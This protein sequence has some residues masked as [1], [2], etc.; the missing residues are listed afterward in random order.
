MDKK[1]FQEYINQVADV[2]YLKPVKTPGIR[3]DNNAND[4]VRY[5]DEWV[6]L[7]AKENPTLGFKFKKLKN[8]IKPC[9]LGCGEMVENQIVEKRLATTP[10]THW[11]TRCNNC[12]C[13]LSPD[14]EG[15]LKGGHA[16]AAAYLKFFN[17]MKINEEWKTA[18]NPSEINDRE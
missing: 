12:G 8:S 2:E 16:V 17:G 13:Y 6:A 3:L 18:T 4:I 1:K 5:G 9:E 7:T 15:F 10:K 11:R 14:G